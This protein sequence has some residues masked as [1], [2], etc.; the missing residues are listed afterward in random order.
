MHFVDEVTVIVTSGAGGGGCSA[1]RREAHVPRG[2]PSGGD[3]GKGGDVLL[4]ADERV[5]TLLDLRYR[6]HLKATRGR[7]GE[8]NHRTGA[9]GD[10]RVVPV[11]VGTLAYDHN[12]GELLGD[13][14][15]PGQTL[16][17]AQGGLG[18]KGNARFRSATHRAPDEATEGG[19]AVTRNLRLELKLLADVGLVGLPNAGKSTLISRLS[20]AKPR[21]ADYPFTTLVPNL[22]VVE[23]D[24]SETF[25]VAD[26]PGLIEGAHAGAG[27]GH[28]FLRHI[29]RTGVL[30]YLV[31]HAP[32]ADRDA[33]ESLETL[34]RELTLY[35]EELG[36]RP[37]ICVLNKCDLPD[38]VA[39]ADRVAE[40]AQ[41]AGLPFLQVSAVTGQGLDALVGQLA[42]RV[43][44]S[45]ARR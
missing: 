17:V 3:G 5:H 1:F 33:V 4:S 37:A 7:N 9:A 40:A 18:G 35:D 6:K 42:V 25:V 28:R 34:R 31:D 38:V 41:A 13:L 27:L 36:D 21:V 29:E 45:R 20:K 43:D 26:V 11:P 8:G 24:H 30:V 15:A 23:V 22:G 10:D 44:E 32:E 39:E 14:M 19:P 12:S 2:G 16:V